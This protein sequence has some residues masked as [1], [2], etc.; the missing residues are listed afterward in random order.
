VIP[1][2][3]LDELD[4]PRD[5]PACPADPS[6]NASGQSLA[7]ANLLKLR[8]TYGIAPRKQLPLA[9]RFITWALGRLDAAQGDT[10][11]QSLIDTQRIPIVAH[12]VMRMQSDAIRNEAMVS[13]PGPGNDGRPGDPGPP[14][15]GGSL[16]TCAWWDPAC[17]TCPSSSPSCAPEV[18]TAT[19]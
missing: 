11:K 4:C 17:T 12:T 13:A 7:D 1:N 2:V 14:A 3:G 15:A 9:G 16:P 10:F 6:R 8:V 18:C 5:V 19:G